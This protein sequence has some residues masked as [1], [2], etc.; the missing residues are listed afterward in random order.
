MMDHAEDFNRAFQF[1]GHICPG[2]VV[3]CRA[4][5]LVLE[6][7][8]CSGQLI[9]DSHFAVVENDVCGVDGVQLI[10]G[11]TLGNDSLIIENQG[12]FAFAWVNKQSGEGFRILLKAPLWK[13]AEPLE[14]HHK[15]K[16]GTATPEEKQR[17]IS[18]RGERGCELMEFSDEDLF[19]VEKIVRKIPG[20]PRLHPFVECSSC[21]EPFMK[22]WV[23]MSGD[24]VLCPRCAGELK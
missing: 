24:E 15:V 17:F 6:R 19:H 5:A 9:G 4:S 7:M 2:I 16:N 8:G 23:R 14:L 21:K 13:S 11:C 10:T 18:L 20:K 22:P 1:H 3:G 12:K